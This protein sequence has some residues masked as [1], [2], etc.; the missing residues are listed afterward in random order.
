[1]NSKRKS[2]ID[3]IRAKLKALREKLMFM[4]KEG[5]CSEYVITAIINEEA[6]LKDRLKELTGGTATRN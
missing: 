5:K 3:I 2:E 4:Y 6:R 1:M